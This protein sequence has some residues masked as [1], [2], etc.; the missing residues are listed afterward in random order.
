MSILEITSCG[1][2][3]TVSVFEDGDIDLLDVFNGASFDVFDEFDG[4]QVDLMDF[5]DNGPIDLDDIYSGQLLSVS[6]CADILDLLTTDATASGFL[7]IRNRSNV[8][9]MTR[10]NDY[11]N[12]RAA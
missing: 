1:R 6:T 5:G 11:I 8:L 10:A 7:S 4:A 9:I 2:S 3:I 12:M